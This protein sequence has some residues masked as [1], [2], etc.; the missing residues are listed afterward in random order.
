MPEDSMPEDTVP[1]RAQKQQQS[2]PSHRETLLRAMDDANED[3]ENL[4]KLL[5]GTTRIQWW[6]S[7]GTLMALAPHPIRNVSA[8]WNGQ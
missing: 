4:V 2:L 6:G 1:P 3:G 5:Y 7:D 8:N